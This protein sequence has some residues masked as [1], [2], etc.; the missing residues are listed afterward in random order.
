MSTIWKDCIYLFFPT[1]YTFLFD[2]ENL[3]LFRLI[4]ILFTTDGTLCRD[5]L[6]GTTLPSS[7][8]IGTNVGFYSV[9]FPF[10]ATPYRTPLFLGK[11]L[12]QRVALLLAVPKSLTNTAL[13]S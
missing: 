4:K 13:V 2:T 11:D 10:L 5:Y 6:A 12:G 8:A 7:I 1:D 3:S 9:K